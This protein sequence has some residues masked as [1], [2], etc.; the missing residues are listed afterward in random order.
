M[1]EFIATSDLS[2]GVVQAQHHTK[3]VLIGDP[4]SLK[5]RLIP[6]LEKLDYRVLNEHPIQAKRSG[7]RKVV[8][9]I[10]NSNIK[11]TI[12][13]RPSTA[14]STLALFDYEVISSTMYQGDHYTIEREVDAIVALAVQRPIT[15]VCVACGTN[16]T[17]DSRF[18]RVCGLPN[19]GSEP[20]ELEVLRL[21]AEVR[22][23]H[24]AIITGAGCM[25]GTLLLSLVL[26]LFGNPKGVRGGWALLIAGEILAWLTLLY[27]MVVL[28]RA[29]NPKTTRSELSSNTPHPTSAAAPTLLQPQSAQASVTEKTTDL[30]MDLPRKREAVPIHRD[31]EDTSR[32]G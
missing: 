25:V 2:G 11:L 10:F 14:N 19:N 21:N 1:S 29:L 15:N 20:A 8:G 30:L 31:G 23:G 13:L 24:R 9:K 27:G 32:I 18:C 3:R 7:T 28:H 26:I 16:S 12:A 5:G 6:A 4:E 17:S 22:T